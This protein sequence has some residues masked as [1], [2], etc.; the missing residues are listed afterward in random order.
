MSP[1]TTNHYWTLIH[2]ER[3][4]ILT[5]LDTLTTEQWHSPT[6]CDSWTVEHVT[7]HLTAAARTGT[8]AWMRS[9]VAA[10][11]NTDRHNARRLTPYL[12]PTPHDTLEAYRAS[13]SATIAPTKDYAA[14]LG[15]VIVHGQDM[16]R[17]LGI[18]LT[19]DTEAVREVAQ[20]YIRKD[21][22]VNSHTLAK[23]L[24]F[25]ATDTTFASGEGPTIH[26]PLLD[27][28]MTL[29][30]RPVPPGVLDGD[31]IAILN[32]RVSLGQNP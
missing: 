21:F 31:G 8:W 4:R 32:E 2:T 12:G 6:L 26:G 28:V 19:P 24:S 15:E 11:F 1:A 23:G 25:Q 29:A 20:F 16:A 17:P 27:I 13:L 14:W 30:G 7:A 3:A 10:R 9:I 5:M 18:S 22:A